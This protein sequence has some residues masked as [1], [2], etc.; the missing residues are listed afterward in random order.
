MFYELSRRRYLCEKA[1]LIKN[2]NY[3]PRYKGDKPAFNGDDYVQ[4]TV[5]KFYKMGMKIGPNVPQVGEYV[6][7]VEY[8]QRYYPP[9][10][11]AKKKIGYN[12]TKTEIQRLYEYKE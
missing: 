9:L 6:E 12:I 8:I 11:W 4:I 3:I 7:F 1:E 5:D 10:K 2:G